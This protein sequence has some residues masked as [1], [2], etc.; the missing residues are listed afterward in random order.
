PVLAQTAG[1]QGVVQDPSGA[2]IAGANLTLTN[3]D[4]GLNVRAQ[5]NE[6]G[7]YTFPAV[8]IGN[9]KVEATKAGFGASERPG[10]KL[11]VNQLA[12]VD[13]MLRPGSLTET[14]NVSASA[15]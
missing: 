11:D 7:F 3:V 1:V 6:V 9:Y 4:T 8:P 15:T 10:I 2:V 14:V 12:R 5:T 13:F